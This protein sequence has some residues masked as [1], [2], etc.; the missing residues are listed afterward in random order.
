LPFL[1]LFKRNR[2]ISVTQLVFVWFGGAILAGTFLL[3]LPISLAEGDTSLDFMSA[4][5]TS[6]S[7]A[8]VT[9]LTVVN[10]AETFSPFGQAVIFLLMEVGGL[11]IMTF[12]VIGFSIF[13]RR[14]SL[15]HQMAAA[16]T[17]YQ[18]E[19]PVEF[20]RAFTQILKV[21]MG[22]QAL[23]AIGMALALIP[24][25]WGGDGGPVF[26]AWSAVFHAASAF[27]NSGFTLY[28]DSL[29]SLYGNIPFLIILMTMVTLGGLGHMT[30][31][32]LSRLPG[33]IRRGERK[34]RWISLH[35][36]VTLSVTAVLIV[37]GV[38][39]IWLL[40]TGDK[41]EG[42]W[43]AT[44]ETVVGRTAGFSLC[45]Q[46]GLPLPSILLVVL[47]MFIGGSPGSCAGG[48]KTT[49]LA[50]WISRIKS[51][52]R[53]DPNVNLFGYTIAPEL[54]SRARILMALTM[55]WN[56]AGVFILSVLHPEEPL[57]V[58]IFEQVSAFGTVG[59]SMD[60]T[61]RLIDLSRIWIC[62]SMFVGRLGP[63]SIALWMI[64]ASKAKVNR[65]IGRLMV[66]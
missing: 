8:C 47:L 64:P 51:N 11:G 45:P 63:L 21:N 15:S 58:L 18:S 24:R 54:V 23:G 26:I 37:F 46:N 59:L 14:L 53:N 60:F 44:F 55:L 16:D 2:R 57:Q 40:G 52:L 9:G 62:V 17:L 49:S 35:T 1:S 28:R 3:W 56:L 65:P 5:F 33:F 31:N 22:I 32:E 30:L 42:I 19:A 36:R 6:V 43:Q 7:A 20:R 48:I 4:L 29:Q 41:G 25:H 27:C 34:P 39:G 61:P 50:I 10:V 66:G 13:G 12:A 38:A